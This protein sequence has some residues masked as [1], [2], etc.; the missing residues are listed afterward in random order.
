M[1]PSQMIRVRDFTHHQA[2]QFNRIKS[3]IKRGR[4]P[5]ALVSAAALNA[6]NEVSPSQARIE[7]PEQEVLLDALVIN[8]VSNGV[9]IRKAFRDQVESRIERSQAYEDNG[10]SLAGR[11]RRDRMAEV[12]D[13]QA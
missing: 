8:Y 5:A 10:D 3:M 11:S 2:Q 13:E 12:M 1:K 9:E 4:L 6:H 7:H